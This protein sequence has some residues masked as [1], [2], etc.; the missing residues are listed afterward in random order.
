MLEELYIKRIIRLA[1]EEFVTSLS[2]LHE[3]LRLR[4]S[5][6][7]DEQGKRSWSIPSEHIF[8]CGDNAPCIDSH[9]WGPLSVHNV[10]GI[11]I[12]KFP[13][14]TSTHSISRL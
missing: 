14:K 10:L 12:L 2:D 6:F 8:V 9:V 11:V 1:G 13:C 7:Y 5:I 3:A 4:E